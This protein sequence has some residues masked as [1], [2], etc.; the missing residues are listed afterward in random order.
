IKSVAVLWADAAERDVN[1]IRAAAVWL[2]LKAVTIPVSQPDDL[3]LSLQQ[4]LDS[5]PDAL[6]AIS[7]PLIN[8]FADRI[9][10][11]ALQ[12]RLPTISE[13]NE[14][15][16]AGGLM[17]YGANVIELSHRAATYVDK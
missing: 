11:F 2:G 1:E 14:F 8:S 12:H 16:A 17:A 5:Q 7:T 13:Q 6:V 15:A 3:E 9:A 4:V 10:Q